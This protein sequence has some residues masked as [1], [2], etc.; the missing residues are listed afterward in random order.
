M[1]KERNNVWISIIFLTTDET[2]NECIIVVDDDDTVFAVLIG[3]VEGEG[4]TNRR[5]V[6]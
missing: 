4:H 1:L 5:K 2:S 3:E 6:I